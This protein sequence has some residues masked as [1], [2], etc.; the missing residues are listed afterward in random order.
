M[1]LQLRSSAEVD[2]LLSKPAPLAKVPFFIII[3]LE[4]AF[5][6]ESVPCEEPLIRSAFGMV[7]TSHHDETLESK[8]GRG[9]RNLLGSV[10]HFADCWG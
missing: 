7:C 3:A 9:S 4:L 10:V 5:R 1:S 8:I 6:L 2:R